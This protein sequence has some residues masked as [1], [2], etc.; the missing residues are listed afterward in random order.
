MFHKV[1]VIFLL[2][3]LTAAGIRFFVHS[4]MNASGILLLKH[5][6]IL[7]L[8]QKGKFGSDVS[9][10]SKKRNC[11]FGRTLNTRRK[12]CQTPGA[13]LLHSRQTSAKQ[14]FNF[15]AAHLIP[16]FRCFHKYILLMCFGHKRE[17]VNRENSGLTLAAGFNCIEL[18]SGVLRNFDFWRLLIDV[19]E[20]QVSYIS[21]ITCLTWLKC[22]WRSLVSRNVHVLHTAELKFWQCGITEPRPLAQPDQ[23]S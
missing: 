13:R 21:E 22:D 11:L 1:T 2:S 14:H 7:L 17:S 18:C 6:C 19:N 8:E 3:E 12:S 9:K 23:I 5:T 4:T 15:S 20:R 16:C 10:R